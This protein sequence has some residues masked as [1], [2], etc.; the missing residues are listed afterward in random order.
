MYDDSFRNKG[1]SNMGRVTIPLRVCESRKCFESSM[2]GA[3]GSYPTSRIELD[4]DE[5]KRGDEILFDES[6]KE[7]SLR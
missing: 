5:S 6:N 3:G 2:D 4:F 1:L 7:M